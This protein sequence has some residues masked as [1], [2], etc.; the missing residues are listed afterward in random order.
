MSFNGSQ[1]GSVKE[2]F[3]AAVSSGKYVHVNI[4][5]RDQQSKSNFDQEFLEEIVDN[6]MDDN[7]HELLH[8]KLSKSDT[9]MDGNEKKFNYNFGEEIPIMIGEFSNDSCD[10]K[11]N[12]QCDND[13][14]GSQYEETEILE[15]VDECIDGIHD[16]DFV[17][18][19][20]NLRRVV[21]A[22][23]CNRR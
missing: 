15:G 11:E 19:E 14:A 23:I 7:V 17:L 8:Q 5:N 16:I 9:S 13:N 20:S 1:F 12:N 6:W 3:T 21:K 2:L 10:K 4:D 18:M 22:S